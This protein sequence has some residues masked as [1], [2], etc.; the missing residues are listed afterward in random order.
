MRTERRAAKGSH[1]PWCPDPDLAKFWL[2]VRTAS[3]SRLRL[4]L[5][6]TSSSRA[7]W[8]SCRVTPA[9]AGMAA[10]TAAYI[11]E[12]GL[13]LPVVPGLETFVLYARPP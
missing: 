13:L 10:E 5:V 12:S 7:S 1:R 9:S 3:S 8:S 2:A 4:C 11:W 6:S